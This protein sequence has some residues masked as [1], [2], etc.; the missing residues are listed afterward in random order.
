MRAT[1]EAGRRAGRAE[2][3]FLLRLL[4]VML[5]PLRLL[6]RVDLYALKSL[7]GTSPRGVRDRNGGQRSRRCTEAGVR[8]SVDVD[9][10]FGG[11]GATERGVCGCSLRADVYRVASKRI[12][13]FMGCADFRGCSLGS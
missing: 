8:G 3:S 13:L 10:E 4:F 5:L 12:F 7:P 1:S 2:G 11:R 9:R 6:L